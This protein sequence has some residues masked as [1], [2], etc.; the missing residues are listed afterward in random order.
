M[1]GSD[2][3]ALAQ[4]TCSSRASPTSSARVSRRRSPVASRAVKVSGLVDDDRVLATHFELHALEPA[5][6]RSDACSVLVDLDSDVPGARERDEADARIVDELEA[7]AG[8]GSGDITHHIAGQT[9]VVEQLYQP[10]H[11]GR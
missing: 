1:A 6:P 8:S 3:P 5:L 2:R 9:G 10:G 4:T 7:D 11:G